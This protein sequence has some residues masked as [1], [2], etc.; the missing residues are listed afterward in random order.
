[1][2]RRPELRPFLQQAITSH[3]QSSGYTVVLG[4]DEAIVNK[5]ILTLG[6][7]LSPKERRMSRLV[8]QL[9][10]EKNR[11]KDEGGTRTPTFQYEPDLFLQG[12]VVVS[13]WCLLC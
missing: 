13:C 11:E 3:L 4:E 9:E 7:F 10:E 6:L 2:E 8:C 1:L 12:Y 5:M